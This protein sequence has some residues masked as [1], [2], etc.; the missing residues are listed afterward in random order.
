[1]RFILLLSC[2]LTVS[3]FA[4]NLTTSSIGVS[5]TGAQQISIDLQN[6]YFCTADSIPMQQEVLLTSTCGDSIWVNL[7]GFHS[8]LPILTYCEIED[9]TGN[10]PRGY[11][12]YSYM[13]TVD[14]NSNCDNWVV[15]YFSGTRMGAS[16][17]VDGQS[18]SLIHISEPTRPY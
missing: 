14:L 8:P 17:V 12:R 9:C 16:N 3:G 7:V 13:D 6:I 11:T 5:W 18:L 15:H 10:T 2:L 1:M 4:N